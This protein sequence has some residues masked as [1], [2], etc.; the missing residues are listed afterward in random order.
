MEGRPIT[1]PIEIQLLPCNAGKDIKA[2]EQITNI[3]N[4]VYAKAEKGFWMDGTKRTTVDEISALTRNGEMAVARMKGKI[5]GCIRIHQADDETGEFGM[6]AVDDHYQ[7][8]GIGRK[9]IRFAEHKCQKENLRKM[10]LELLVPQEGSHPT[11]LS[12]ENWYIRIGYHPVHTVSVE[13]LFPQL[14]QMLAIPSKF[15]IFRKELEM[16]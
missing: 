6:L 16:Q 15:I 7:G 13:S 10:Q 11:K 8:A 14:A 4:R 1:Q 2:M 3:I 12:L 9:L 5:V